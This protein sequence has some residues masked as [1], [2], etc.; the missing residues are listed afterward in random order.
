MYPYWVHLIWQGSI[1]YRCSSNDSRGSQ[2][3][4]VFA[5]SCR[6]RGWCR[7]QIWRWCRWQHLRRIRCQISLSLGWISLSLS[8]LL[9][10]MLGWHVLLGYKELRF[11]TAI[12]RL[13][14]K[15]RGQILNSCH[16][17]CGRLVRSSLRWHRRRCRG[18]KK[19]RFCTDIPRV[20]KKKTHPFI[21][22]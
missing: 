20:S 13:C 12:W 5:T 10:L 11:C 2:P 7:W 8:G 1:G 15:M 19:L 21:Y 9:E 22:E 4:I 18:Y 3:K 17:I 14:L 16:W 6:I